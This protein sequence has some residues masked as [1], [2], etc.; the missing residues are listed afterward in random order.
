MVLREDTE[1]QEDR[2]QVIWQAMVTFD[3]HIG[4][5]AEVRFQFCS[6]VFVQIPPFYA[7]FRPV[8]KEATY[9]S[10][11]KWKPTT[12]AQ[13]MFGLICHILW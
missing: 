6:K 9:C 7:C 5:V 3:D 2:F 10:Y 1:I 13:D 8:C 4:N 12:S 11:G